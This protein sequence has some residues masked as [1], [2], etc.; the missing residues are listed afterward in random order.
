MAKRVFLHDGQRFCAASINLPTHKV[1]LGPR[2]RNVVLERKYGSPT[3]CRRC[4]GG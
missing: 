4:H 2:G 1:T 3:I